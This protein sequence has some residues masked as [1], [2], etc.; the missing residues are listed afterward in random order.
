MT[1]DAEKLKDRLIRSR[2]QE[3]GELPAF[4]SDS[5][6]VEKNNV[7][8]YPVY[9]LI[10]ERAEGNI[11]YLFHSDYVHPMRKNE[12]SFI[13]WL[14]R[15]TGMA[16]TVPMYL[17][18]PEHDCEEVFDIL[19]PAYQVYCKRREAGNLILMGSGAGAGLAVSLMLQI[20]KEG[21]S[22]PDKVLRFS[23]VLDTEFFDP[24]LE[25]GVMRKMGEKS[26][27]PM[28]ELLNE[29]WVKNYA[30]RM[31]FT[32]PVYED[33]HDISQDIIVV[34]GT[35][36]YF[37]IYARYFSTKVQDTGN[38]LKYFEYGGA[39]RDFF[40][41]PERKETK[42]LQKIL[43]D[44]L[45]DTDEEIIY[46]YMEEVRQRAGWSKFFP[47][48][49]TDEHAVKYVAAH[50]VRGKKEIHSQNIFNL[51]GASVQRAYDEAVNLFLKEYPDG[52]VIYVGCSLDTMLERV[53]NGRVMWYNLD[54]PGR[55]AI[56]TMYTGL[57]KREK[58]IERSVHDLSWMKKLSLETDRGV[59]F[60]IKDIFAYMSRKEVREFLD[61]LYK[62][63]QGCNVLFDMATPR[64]NFMFNLL[65]RGRGGEYRKKH[66]AM[67]DPRREVEAMSPIYHVV[68]VRSVVD[69][70][71]PRKD[72]RMG[73][74]LQLM[75]NRRRDAWKIVH[76][77][78][79][80]ERYKTFREMETH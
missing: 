71:R 79:G 47:E 49:F 11:F 52:N 8:G 73:L 38:P 41:H 60:V 18:A 76:I 10:P 28:K 61:Q 42:H 68:T 78:L 56:R 45:L 69:D 64:A 44:F 19:I 20:W 50:P 23:P 67:R 51:M 58:R 74:K 1:Q 6:A 72:W 54:S 43:H 32:A 75:S 22:D 70:I 59:L 14:C 15:M 33:L 13:R 5:F 31:E 37:N 30:G 40:L 53:D 16:V 80:Y 21:L 17:L 2:K 62:N 66:L 7:H 36:D 24:Q 27:L 29:T 63:F 65:G 46:Q 57:G 55:M 12:W 35:K 77:R 39:E 9:R 26:F 3:D 25:K 34:S 4:I 48:I